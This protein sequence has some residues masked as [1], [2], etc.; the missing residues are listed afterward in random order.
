MN[1]LIILLVVLIVLILFYTYFKDF[2]LGT[3][4]VSSQSSLNSA[5]IPPILSTTFNTPNSTRYTYGIWLYVNTWTPSAEKVIFSRYN[6]ILLYLDETTATLNCKM[7]P[8]YSSTDVNKGSASSVMSPDLLNTSDTSSPIIQVT[9][10]FP[11]QKW[12]FITV[13]VDNTTVDIYLDGK[14][15]KS[16]QVSQVSPD[17]SSALYFGH[18]WDAYIVNFQRWSYPMDP[19]SVWNTYLGGNGISTT[20]TFGY[21]ANLN[22][23]K[24]DVTQRTYN[25]F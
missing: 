16:V 1:W 14:L 21:H 7:S 24:N 11:L 18:G 4:T 19:Q 13:V 10:N 22:I 15:V 17:K 3:T 9:N 20:S 23:L 8:T 25:L 5:T 6:D 12:V 2:F